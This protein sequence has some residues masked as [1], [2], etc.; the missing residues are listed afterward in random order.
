MWLRKREKLEIDVE[1]PVLLLVDRM[2]VD[3]CVMVANSTALTWKYEI[4]N[5]HFCILCKLRTKKKSDNH[6]HTYMPHMT[7]CATAHS[8][9]FHN[10]ISWMLMHCTC[11]VRWKH[12]IHRQAIKNVHVR[13]YLLYRIKSMSTDFYFWVVNNI[14]CLHWDFHFMGTVPK[15]NNTNYFFS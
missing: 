13:C 10:S 8:L 14:C 15:S 4:I 11:I 3:F 12:K 6:T 2:N 7:K 1:N 5:V 9:R